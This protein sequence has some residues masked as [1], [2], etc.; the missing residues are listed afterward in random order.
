MGHLLC[1]KFKKVEGWGQ[2]ELVRELAASGSSL[3]LCLRLGLLVSTSAPSSPLYLLPLLS[4][5]SCFRPASL[6]SLLT[7]LPIPV[8]T[9]LKSVWVRGKVYCQAP[10]QSRSRQDKVACKRDTVGM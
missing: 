7:P 3:T 5:S 2:A 6:C 8:H 9:R 1:M 4:F 10:N